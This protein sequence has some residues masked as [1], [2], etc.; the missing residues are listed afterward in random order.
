MINKNGLFYYY[1]IKRLQNLEKK[2]NILSLK[3]INIVNNYQHKYNK[4]IV[5]I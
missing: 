5:N 2:D 4:S 1:M 3:Y